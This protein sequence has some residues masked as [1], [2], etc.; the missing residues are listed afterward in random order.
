MSLIEIEISQGG[1]PS[2]IL[3]ILGLYMDEIRPIGLPIAE[4]FGCHIG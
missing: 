1:I 3:L 2:P 4:I